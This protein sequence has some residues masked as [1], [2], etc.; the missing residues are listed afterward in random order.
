[1]ILK[2]AY[3]PSDFHNDGSES[4]SSPNLL[5]Q[6]VLNHQLLAIAFFF[7]FSP[8]T[9]LRYLPLSG[10]DFV[11]FPFFSSMQSGLFAVH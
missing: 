6:N 10:L 5:I 2:K 7:F 9:F 1:M 4:M 8:G 3:S 11:L